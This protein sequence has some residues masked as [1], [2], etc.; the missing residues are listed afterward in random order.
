[1]STDLHYVDSPPYGTL[2][3]LHIM[4]FLYEASRSHS[5]DTLHLGGLLWTSDLPDAKTSA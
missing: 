5:L 3:Q 4:A 1:M 2:T